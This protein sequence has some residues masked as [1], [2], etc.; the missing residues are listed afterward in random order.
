MAGNTGEALCAHPCCVAWFLLGHRSVPACVLGAGKPP[1]PHSRE[2]LPIQ[3]LPSQRRNILN[4]Y[5]CVID[6]STTQG[7]RPLSVYLLVYCPLGRH[8]WDFLWYLLWCAGWWHQMGTL[9]SLPQPPLGDQLGLPGSTEALAQLDLLH[10]IW[11]PLR[12]GRGSC[13]NCTRLGPSR[14]PC[15]LATGDGARP[16][17]RDFNIR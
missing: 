13:Q 3:G 8:S 9:G 7:P 4:T 1:P 10:D 6:Q 17:S 14:A 5:C 2:S 11:I 12:C 16:A 15:Q